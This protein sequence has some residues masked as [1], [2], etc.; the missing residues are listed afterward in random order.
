MNP[1][2]PPLDCAAGL[3]QGAA[4]RELG[5]AL[6][7]RKGRVSVSDLLASPFEV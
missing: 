5:G 2:Q 4:G 7:L 3:V 6:A 1:V